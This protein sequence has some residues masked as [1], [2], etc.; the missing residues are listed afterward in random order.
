MTQHKGLII[1]FDGP[2]GAGKTTQL[3]LAAE[4]LKKAGH[5]V[6]VTRTMGGTPIGEMLRQ[7]MLTETSRPTETDLHIAVATQYA[8]A[9]EV[10]KHRDKGHIVL[11][12]RSPLS[13][14]GYQV[15]GDGLDSELGYETV[16]D[17]L[18]L[19][20][21][22]LLIIYEADIDLLAERRSKRNQETQVDY[23]ENKPQDYHQ[24][25]AEGFGIAAKKFGATVIKADDSI[26][27]VHQ[28]TMSKIQTLL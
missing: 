28:A 15:H 2:D 16:E 4:A 20:T 3:N 26:E 27:S 21:P 24:K 11:I 23:F 8:L 18:D 12:D 17:L 1:Y 13:I 19:F 9:D 10:I 5:E 7:A 22:N 14:I 6:I 25:V